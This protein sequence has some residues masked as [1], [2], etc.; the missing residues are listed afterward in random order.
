MDVLTDLT[1]SVF[2]IL[3]YK[4]FTSRG[5]RY[6]LSGTKSVCWYS[7]VPNK[8]GDQNKRR[9]RLEGEMEI[10]VK[11]YKPGGREVKINGG[12]WSEFQ[13]IR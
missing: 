12:V 3:V 8:R 2:G 6:E 9:L 11:F 10:F 7:W 13:N 1:P 5:T 4:D